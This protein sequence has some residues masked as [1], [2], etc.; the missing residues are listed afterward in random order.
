MRV[1][2]QTKLRT[3][4]RIVDAARKLFDDKG[5]ERATTRDISIEAGI[6]AGTLFNY[7]SS[8]EALALTILGE[9]LE[10]AESEFQAKRWGGE[11]LAEFLFAL[12][13]SLLRCLRPYR[14][15]ASQVI[16]AQPGPCS[17]PTG[18][19]EPDEALRNYM[20]HVSDLITH[21]GP[22]GGKPPTIITLHLYWT[23]LLGVLSYWAQD[24]SPQQEDTLV[25]LDQSLRMF[26]HSLNDLP[27]RTEL[28]DEPDHL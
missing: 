1:T 20:E 19:Q 9:A 10:Q 3:R 6:A 14:R 8:K 15:F 5:F 13:A 16:E 2:E 7:F 28:S 4:E 23:L 12:T 17:I 18:L 11:S 21:H 24:P 26:V 27:H 25:L 22:P